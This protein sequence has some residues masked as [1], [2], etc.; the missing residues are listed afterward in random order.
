MKRWH[1]LHYF[2]MA[3]ALLLVVIGE[4]IWL[5]DPIRF[6]TKFFWIDALDLLVYL[7]ALIPLIWMAAV[8]LRI[9]AE[10]GVKFL[11][12]AVLTSGAIAA[13][14]ILTVPKHLEFSAGALA[15]TW[16]FVFADLFF[17][18][19]NRRKIPVRTLTVFIWVIGL[20]FI[21]LWPTSYLV[22][23]PGLTMNM[24]RYAQVK[25][26]NLHGDISG[27]LVFERPAFPID[28]LYA[29]LFPHYTFERIDKLGMSL[30]AYNQLIKT[31]KEDANAAGSAIAFQKLGRGKGITTYGVLITNVDPNSAV[32]GIM[33]PGD[34]IEGVNGQS[35]TTVKELSDRMLLIKP[36]NK[37]EVSVQRGDKRVTLQTGTRANPDDPKRAAF[38]IQVSNKFEYDIPETVKYHN[39][40][41]HEGGPS[42][43]AM[44][45]LTLI[46]QL[47][48]DGVTNGNR[49]S[50]TG[51][52]EPD[53]SVGPVGG[54]EQKAYTVSRVGADVF[55]VPFQ[56]EEEARRGAPGL[57]IV[58]VHS[59]D[60]ILNWLRTHPKEGEKE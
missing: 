13:L 60:D 50:G 47:T 11:S 25:G 21:F 7:P 16:L 20:L 40:M 48:P 56:N 18:E 9:L 3:L 10:G 8:V 5:S 34:V 22:T 57:Q 43:G 38:G 54:V 29:K 51:T 49:V 31:M 55:F 39:Y 27:V 12:G 45:A 32:K 44:L 35:V 2:G 58:S 24:N 30:G 26:G 17:D 52:I 23:Y 59:L 6:G 28:W 14:T 41:L 33:L 46:D 4:L 37:V 42:H 19:R 1:R 53:G 15:I 36:G